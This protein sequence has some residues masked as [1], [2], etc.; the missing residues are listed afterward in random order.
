MIHKLIFILI[1]IFSFSA[2]G[3]NLILNPSFEDTVVF[4]WNN[5]FACGPEDSP[6][7]FTGNSSPDYF[8]EIYIIHCSWLI[9]S[10]VFG[11]QY[12]RTGIGYAGFGSAPTHPAHELISYTLVNALIANHK[13][14]FEFY[15]SCAD[16]VKYG[17][18]GIGA[19]FT[20]D[21]LQITAT[22]FYSSQINSLGSPIT[23]TQGW[24]KIS[25]SFFALGNERVIT[26]GNLFND[27][28]TNYVIT[29]PNAALPNAI[30]QYYLDEVYLIDSTLVS[31][32]DI[33]ITNPK[34]I[35]S[36]PVNDYTEVCSQLL[37]QGTFSLYDTFGKLVFENGL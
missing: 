26:I 18:D 12:A 6:P 30:S 3:Q 27:S 35:S 29:N 31:L 19:L 20:D 24:T 8:N 32:E 36:N 10:N 14:Y 4:N 5:P 28:I 11:Y 34:I 15:V 33:L 37:V 17:L 16:S 23:D 25:G 7:W 9:P 13:Y 1:T 22:Y 2:S 21:T